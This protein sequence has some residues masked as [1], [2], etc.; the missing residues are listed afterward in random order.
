VLIVLLN[1]KIAL[2]AFLEFVYVE[3]A[4]FNFLLDAVAIEFNDG[5]GGG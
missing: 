5:L 4:F 3:H 1:E 2:V